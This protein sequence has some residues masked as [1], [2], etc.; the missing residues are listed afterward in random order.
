MNDNVGLTEI[1]TIKPGQAAGT[2]STPADMGSSGLSK[3]EKW[4]FSM[5]NVR[6]LAIVGDVHCAREQWPDLAE[7][8]HKLWNIDSQPIRLSKVSYSVN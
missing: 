7:D 1:A 2:S 8:W 4:T 5:K 3:K 6:K